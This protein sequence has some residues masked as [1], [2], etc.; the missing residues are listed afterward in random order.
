MKI[1]T[2]YL[3]ID[4]A[5][6]A[7]CVQK[8]E[9]ALKQVA[10][11]DDAVMNL[12]DST[13]TVTGKADISSL[14]KAIA[15]AGYTAQSIRDVLSLRAV[16][17]KEQADQRYYKELMRNMWVA[18]SL[19]MALM[20]YG[21]VI[22]DMSVNSPMQRGVWLLVGLLTLSRDGSDRDATFMSVRG[23]RSSTTMQTWIPSLP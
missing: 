2:L 9:G 19:G 10:G 8:I 7:S 22:G 20:L 15:V 5:S 4:G 13:V 17:E 11:V 14:I 1:P 18:L 12:A 23:I 3:H 21:M 16:S 6:C